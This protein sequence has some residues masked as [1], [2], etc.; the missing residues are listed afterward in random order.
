VVGHDAIAFAQGR[1]LAAAGFD[2]ASIQ[3]VSE[4][5]ALGVQVQT[6]SYSAAP[7][8][9][10]AGNGTL[11]YAAPAGGRRLV[12]IDRQQKEEFLKTGEHH[13]SNVRISPDGRRVAICEPDGE[14]DLWLYA[15][16]GSLRLKLSLGP[17]RDTMPVWS[18]DGSLIFLTIGERNIYRVPADGSTAPTLIFQQAPPSRLHPLAITPDGKR[19]LTQWDELPKLI[20]LRVLEF[21]VTPTL[22]PLVGDTSTERDGRLSPDGRWLVYQSEESSEGLEGQIVVRPF[23]E[24]RSERWIISQG[25]GRQPIW[26]RD[27]RE[28]FY[29]TEDG[30]VMSVP[31]TTA[32]RFEHGP[33]S[34]LITSAQTV[35][36]W[37]NGPTY[38]VSP[39]GKRFLF[40]KAPELDIRSLNVVLNWD[41]EVKAALARGGR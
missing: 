2:S 10:V 13:Y 6:A 5:R 9:A 32:P 4:P 20:D 3:L 37:M 17:E 28:I 23:P 15:L 22:T 14:R 39:D 24:I 38:D 31:V 8:Y 21:G 34:R 18:T 33:P 36:D 16:D 1:T 12:W 27:G 25:V 19:L 29:R 30:T 40:I 35:R 7:M 26:S 41:V 11:V